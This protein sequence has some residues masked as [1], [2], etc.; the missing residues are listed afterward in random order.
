[1]TEQME[2]ET[3]KRAQKD[4]QAVHKL[5]CRLLRERVRGEVTLRLDGSGAI[6]SQVLRVVTEISIEPCGDGRRG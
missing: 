2:C 1:M 6:R 3:C 4:L 5:L